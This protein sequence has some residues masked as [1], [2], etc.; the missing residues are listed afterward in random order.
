ML[1][2]VNSRAVSGLVVLAGV[3]VLTAFAWRLLD[4]PPTY[5]PKTALTEQCDGVPD[6]AERIMLSRPAGM[7][8]GA[9]LVGPPGARVGVVLRQGAGQ[10]ICQWLPWA[11]D[12]AEA[13]GARVL[14]FDRRGRGSS[15]GEADLTAEPADLADAVGLLRNRGVDEVGLVA[16]SMGNAVA[17]SALGRLSPQPCV[18]VAVSPVLTASDSVGTVDGTS[19]ERLIDNVWVAYEEQND[20]IVA[21]ADLIESRADEMGLPPPQLLPVDT[22]DHSIGLVQ[23]HDEVRDFVVDAIGSCQRVGSVG[24]E[25]RVRPR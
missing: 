19:M 22:A 16:S 15:P 13:T 4:D 9:A 17:F 21:G 8:L 20:S 5:D 1:S 24:P 12:L 23:N 10:T 14:L 11:G 25:E 2:A 7:T 18:V 6:D 3:V